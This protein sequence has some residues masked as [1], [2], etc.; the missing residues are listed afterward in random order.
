M[1]ENTLATGEAIDE[2][3]VAWGGR[4]GGV[5]IRPRWQVAG[6]RLRRGIVFLNVAGL[7][8]FAVA[9]R[10]R[11]LGNLP[12]INGDEAWYGVQAELLLRSERISPRTPSGNLLNPLFFAPQFALHAIFQPSF[13][14][15]R[16]R[17]RSADCWR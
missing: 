7:L 16:T 17:R 15:L 9:L 13:A 8:L 6:Q 1:L 14:L 3:A 2:A 5:E 11:D 10:C 12:G 4:G